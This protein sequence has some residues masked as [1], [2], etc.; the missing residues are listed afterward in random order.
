M[1][2]YKFPA[3][4]VSVLENN[5]AE[6]VIFSDTEFDVGMANHFLE[7]I[8]TKMISPALVLVNKTYSYSYTFEALIA[9]SRSKSLKSVAVLSDRGTVSSLVS[10]LSKRF[11]FHKVPVKTF[12]ER[13]PAIQWLKSINY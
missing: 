5:I 2:T 3:F 7:V 1:V 11:N 10:Y 9:F 13:E 8:E 4:Q 6:L 12:D